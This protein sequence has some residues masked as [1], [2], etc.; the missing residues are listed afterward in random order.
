MILLLHGGQASASLLL[1]YVYNIH[2]LIVV[3]LGHFTLHFAVH[4]PVIQ[5]STNNLHHP[6]SQT[7]PT[8]EMQQFDSFDISTLC[9]E[10]VRNY[11]KEAT[12]SVG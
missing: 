1:L 9:A 5:T 8:E 11:L 7:V 2:V 4:E 10:D 12:W 6:P 3:N